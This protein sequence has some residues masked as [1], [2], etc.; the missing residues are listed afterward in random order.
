M[1]T[2]IYSR[3]RLRR[4]VEKR[5][6]PSMATLICSRPNADLLTLEA[7]APLIYSRFH[8]DLLTPYI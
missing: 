5:N 6:F 1:S 4:P 7:S 3:R 2:L 8:A